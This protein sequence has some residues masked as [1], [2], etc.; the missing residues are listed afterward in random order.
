MKLNTLFKLAL[1]P[2]TIRSA[3][4]LTKKKFNIINDRFNSIF[5]NQYRGRT[6]T[7]RIIVNPIKN[8]FTNRDERIDSMLENLKQKGE[9]KFRQYKTFSRAAEN[10]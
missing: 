4:N 3:A 6:A 2:E 10:S 9:R 7:E 5:E 8:I 1:K